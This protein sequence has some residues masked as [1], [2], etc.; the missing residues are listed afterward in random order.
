[1]PRAPLGPLVVLSAPAACAAAA[2]GGP[3]NIFE[4]GSHMNHLE[5]LYF[6]TAIVVI[7]AILETVLHR[8]EHRLAHDRKH[9][10]LKL[11]NLTLRDMMLLGLISFALFLWTS[12]NPDAEDLVEVKFANS[13]VVFMAIFLMVS[14]PFFV[15][16]M[17]L[18]WKIA[19]QHTSL[20]ELMD[21]AA[22]TDRG[23]LY[24]LGHPFKIMSY[25]K[26]KLKLEYHLFRSC[27][28]HIYGEEVGKSF[29]YTKYCKRM[30][31]KLVIRLVTI[32]PASWL[33]FIVT[34]LSLM[35][36]QKRLDGP[37]LSLAGLCIF[38]WTALAVEVGAFVL[39][40]RAFGRAQQAM[41]VKHPF[42]TGSEAEALR[43]VWVSQRGTLTES[44]NSTARRPSLTKTPSL[45]MSLKRL[46]I[47]QE[48]E[49]LSI[50]KGAFHL[51]T[52]RGIAGEGSKPVH[53]GSEEGFLM[54]LDECIL[55]KAFYLA[56]YCSY[57]IGHSIGE[58]KHKGVNGWVWVLTLPIPAVL[59]L[60]P[61]TL[62][63]PHHSL[64]ATVRE[65][66]TKLI[67][68]MHE[69]EEAAHRARRDVLEKLAAKLEG[70]LRNR[71]K[72]PSVQEVTSYWFRE[73]DADNSGQITPKELWAGLNDLDVSLARAEQQEFW[74]LADPQ[75]RGYIG[76]EELH[77]FLTVAHEA[78]GDGI[79]ELLQRKISQRHMEAL[80]GE[81][82]EGN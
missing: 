54:L 76:P 20:R 78:S 45:M 35:V 82:D 80:A 26:T 79:D 57:A 43:R 74:R 66:N 62:I 18:T 58:G 24:H 81:R 44:S 47:L 39:I 37:H 22:A 61:W 14:T 2:A 55:L 12:V 50:L 70:C 52:L 30:A 6:F 9:F 72:F 28:L 64:I 75:H 71:A 29:Y 38:G 56:L 17:R 19:E 15:Y 8:Y 32:A 40:R 49:K 31:E 60:I 53:I 11:L 59:G 67:A 51:F 73:W 33:L 7:L 48:Q 65:L 4:F 5:F 69:E 68:Q 27:F 25:F 77:V 23:L 13:V 3:S 36:L 46:P 21:E 1:M 10:K 34:L 41:G 63:I 16:P 42:V